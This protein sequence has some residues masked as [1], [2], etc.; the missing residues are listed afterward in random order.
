MESSGR[1]TFLNY[2]LI[3]IANNYLI[4]SYASYCPKI[5][6]NHLMKTMNLETGT[7]TSTPFSYMGIDTQCSSVVFKSRLWQSKR[8]N[9][10]NLTT[11]YFKPLHSTISSLGKFSFTR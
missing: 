6:I 7:I 10:G 2:K 3:M 9:P 11:E 5:Y 4:L 1:V 8:L